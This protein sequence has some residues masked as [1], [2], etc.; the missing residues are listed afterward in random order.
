MNNSVHPNPQRSRLERF[1]YQI[2]SRLGIRPK[3]EKELLETDDTLK[4]YKEFKDRGM[5]STLY[6]LRINFLKGWT[7]KL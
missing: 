6:Y 1:I 5:C 4:A 7:I 2:Q 3:W